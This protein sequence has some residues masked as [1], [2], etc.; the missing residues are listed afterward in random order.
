GQGYETGA[1]TYLDVLEAQRVVNDLRTR[2]I[3]ALKTYHLTKG[4]LDRLN[5]RFAA[6]LPGEEPE[7]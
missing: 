6:A 4:E 3:S 5:E 2:Y 1:F 7:S